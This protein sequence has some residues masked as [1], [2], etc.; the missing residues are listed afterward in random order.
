[1]NGGNG[2]GNGGGGGHHHVSHHDY[3]PLYGHLTSFGTVVGRSA[4]PSASPPL[5][6]A[7]LSAAAAVVDVLSAGHQQQQQQQ[8]LTA[9][10]AFTASAVPANSPMD[11]SIGWWRENNL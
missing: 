11:Y 8:Q 1:M 9:L 2:G 6:A 3:D 5:S 4:C 7:H 10:S